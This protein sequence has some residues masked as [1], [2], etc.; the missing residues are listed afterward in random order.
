MTPGWRPA[1]TA[2][3][4]AELDP[5]VIDLPGAGRRPGAAGGRRSG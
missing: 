4:F 1:L 5:V 2:A 3:T